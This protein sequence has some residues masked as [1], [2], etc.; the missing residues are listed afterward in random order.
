MLRQKKYHKIYRGW[1]GVSLVGHRASIEKQKGEKV[2]RSKK[3]E[4]VRKG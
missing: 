4:R 3:V 1:G 2:L